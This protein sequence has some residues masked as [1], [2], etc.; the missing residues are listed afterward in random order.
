MASQRAL[1]PTKP[2][3]QQSRTRTTGYA[4][5]HPFGRKWGLIGVLRVP[6]TDD[7]RRCPS[8]LLCSVFFFD[9][10][11]GAH[12]RVTVGDLNLLIYTI[13]LTIQR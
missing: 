13:D 11:H 10:V 12:L 9:F 8:C 3:V 4:K 2:N 7:T 6:E 1:F 5:K